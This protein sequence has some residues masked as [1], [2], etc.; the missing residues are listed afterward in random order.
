MAEKDQDKPHLAAQGGGGSV[1][2]LSTHSTPFLKKSDEDKLYS[3][4]LAESS[5]RIA[6]EISTGSS[7]S[8]GSS[9]DFLGTGSSSA[10]ARQMMQD[11]RCACMQSFMYPFVCSLVS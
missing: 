2:D 6:R 4:T 11:E 3:P 9:S 5:G 10:V 7:S 1:V 8:A